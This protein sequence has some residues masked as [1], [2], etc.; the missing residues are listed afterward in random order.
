MHNLDEGCQ[1]PH[2][3]RAPRAD[4]LDTPADVI[5]TPADVVCTPADV[6][7]TPADV[8]CTPAD[9]IDTVADRSAECTTAMKDAND[10]MTVE[11]LVQSTSANQPVFACHLSF[12]IHL[13]SERTSERKRVSGCF[14]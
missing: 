11:R 5:A 3:G 7:F 8:I 13:L 4:F 6:I 9:V 1:R 14:V 10:P 12:S 2:G